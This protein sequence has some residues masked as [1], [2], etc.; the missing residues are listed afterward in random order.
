MLLPLS[1]P[2]ELPGG[3]VLDPHSTGFSWWAPRPPA[4]PPDLL[5]QLP[6]LLRR[7]TAGPPLPAAAPALLVVPD[8]TRATFVRPMAE[9][10]VGAWREAGLHAEDI[11]L[12]IA[13]GL[14]RPPTSAEL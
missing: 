1:K 2:A 11:E 12:Q 13:G 5:R 6:N 4:E 9:A 10:V 8:A 14:H 3:V 7:P